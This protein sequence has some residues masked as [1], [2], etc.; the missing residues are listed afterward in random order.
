MNTRISESQS[1]EVA[2]RN[3]IHVVMAEAV[4]AEGWFHQ[5]GVLLNDRQPEQLAK[6]SMTFV[7]YRRA[8]EQRAA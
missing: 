2:L 5:A 4:G 8:R 7:G 1:L 3:R 6:P